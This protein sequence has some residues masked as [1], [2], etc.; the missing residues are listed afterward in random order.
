MTISRAFL[1]LPGQEFDPPAPDADPADF[2]GALRRLASGVSVVTTGS[3]A[4]RT[5]LTVTSVASLSA[6]PPCVVFGLNVAGSSLPVLERFRAFGVNVLAERHQPVAERFSGRGGIKGPERYA[7]A[8]W[9][10]LA[11]GASI[12]ADAPAALDCELEE[13]IPRHSQAIVVGRVKAVH[14]GSAADAL[15]YWQAGY[16]GLG[17]RP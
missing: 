3:G 5:G 8:D 15:L 16:A 10:A 13:L 7:G 12:L 6:E 11:T 1:P 17:G 4:E 9:I 2:R 14:L